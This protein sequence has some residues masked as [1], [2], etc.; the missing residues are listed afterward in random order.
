MIRVVLGGGFDRDGA[1]CA[2]EFDANGLSG[3]CQ[4]HA[5]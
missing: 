1:K 5:K 2:I 4:S 3:R